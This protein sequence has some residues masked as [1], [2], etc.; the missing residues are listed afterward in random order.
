[1]L[2]SHLG[3]F[4]SSTLSSVSKKVFGKCL[5]EITVLRLHQTNHIL[6]KVILREI[7]RKTNLKAFFHLLLTILLD[8]LPKEAS[9][10]G[11]AM[12]TQ[13]HP[14]HSP[15]SAALAGPP[16]VSLLVPG[17]GVAAPSFT[18]SVHQKPGM[19]GQLSPHTPTT[20]Y[21]T[22]Q[23][24]QQFVFIYRTTFILPLFDQI[25]FQHN[26]QGS[27]SALFLVDHQ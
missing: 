1:M 3:F 26:L 14:Q 11:G 20:N 9:P 19:S 4:R 24:M 17:P 5:S 12:P 22:N 25:I 2:F 27:D 13:V 15:F 18:S 8:L 7:L 10:L 23:G 16:N 6:K 21:Y